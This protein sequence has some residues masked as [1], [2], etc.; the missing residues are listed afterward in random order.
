MA[1]PC[2]RRPYNSTLSPRGVHKHF[3]AWRN[4]QEYSGG[5]MTDFGAHHFDIAQWGLGMDESGPVE[6]IPPENPQSFV[7]LEFRYANGV[8]MYHGG[9]SGITFVG[10]SG[11]IA[12]DRNR[13]TSI[14]DSILKEPWATRTFISSSRRATPRIGSIASSRES[15]RSPTSRSVPAA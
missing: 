9:P 13:L 11:V 2:P 10:T 8:K 6:V 15:G 5:G 3:P 1:R 14:P 12:V 7:G 4:Y